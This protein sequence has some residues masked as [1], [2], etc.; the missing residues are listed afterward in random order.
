[1]AQKDGEPDTNAGSSAA[2]AATIAPISDSGTEATI[3]APSSTGPTNPH[4]RPLAE[5][6]PEVSAAHY[7][8][9]REIARG[10]M[11][12]IVAAE[13]R[14]LH[15]RV[16]LKSL[17][18]PAGDHI[19]RFQREALITARLQHPGIVPVYEAGKWPNGEPFFAMKL[20]SGRPLDKVIAEASRLEDR[21][22]IIP[23][24]AAACD[25]IAYAHSQ[26]IIHR[27]LKPGN[28]LIGDYGET[29]V[30]DWGLAKD[31]DAT[32]THDSYKRD[33]KP[34][35]ARDEATTQ[36]STLTIAGAVMGTPAYMAPEQARGEPLDQ[37]ADVFSLGAMLYHTL[38][39]VP[40]YNARTATDVIAAAALGKIVPLSQRER[41]AP[42]DLVAIVTRAMA[43][44]PYD[45]YPDA[46]ELASELRRFLTGQLVGAHRYTTLQRVTRFVRMHRAAVTISVVA[47]AGFA[48][49][50]TVAI[51]NIVEARDRARREEQIAIT[52]QEA[53]EHLIDYMLDDMKTRLS[54][55]GRLD[56]L[57]GLGNEVKNYYKKLSDMPGG[58]P[59]EDEIRM[60]QAIELIG[61]AEQTSG[62]PDQALATWREARE[63]LTT[64]IGTDTSAATHR[65]RMMIARFDYEAGR[66]F[67]ERGKPKEALDYFEKAKTAFDKLRD[68]DPRDK[69][70][71]LAAGDTH[72]RLG[73]LLRIDGKIDEAFDEYNAGKAEREKAQQLGDG[74]TSDALLAVSTSHFKLA[75][76]F[77]NRGE[78][79]AAL[80]EYQ[81][82]RRL[83][84]TLLEG[85]PDNVQYQEAVLDVQRELGELQRQL[86][87]TTAAI[88]T[89]K[90]ALPVAQSLM[91]RDPT[92]TDWQYA[93]GNLMS[94]LGY[95]LI[96][97]GAYND[98]IAR[99]TEAAEV[100][101]GLVAL[102]PKSA[103]YRTALS[104]T[105]MRM[106]DAHLALGQMAEALTD[107]RQALEL[108]EE[109][110]D[111]DTKNVAYRR[112]VAWAYAKLAM[113][114]TTSGREPQ[115]I[116]AHE[117]ALDIRKALV[118]ESPSQGGFKNELASSEVELGRLLAAKE[119]KRAAELIKSGLD[120]AH[121]LVAGDMINIEWKETLTQGLLA[122]A[123]LA[124][125][126]ADTALRDASLQEA[127]DV[128]TDALSHAPHNAS[129]PCYLAEIH[130]ARREWKLARDLLEPLDKA[131]RLP[132]QRRPLLDRARAQR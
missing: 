14:R 12:K 93:R 68:E 57:A 131:S 66:V 11:G 82:A 106:G 104:K 56:L 27:D 22:A 49:G 1:M 63:R 62:N 76:I 78:S 53:A 130:I 32:D 88:D 122:R 3:A 52:R 110:I 26:R 8:T 31:L 51:N 95:T 28:V 128:A 112:S 114:Y 13:D 108:R 127:L 7:V 71:L 42:A 37:R 38:A 101:R 30:I 69:A 34:K 39:G 86:G 91:Q 48:I 9:E 10:G 129:W 121:M 67:Q 132:A 98:G 97:S 21:L 80:E 64:V 60:A 20:V 43:Q 126:T 99:V 41:R 19:T 103:R 45:R 118:A 65:L 18:D 15:R 58:M 73:D 120:R 105:N 119:P 87:D 5:D 77:Q 124:T 100:L 113:A 36:S 96:D 102:D 54:A 2:F 107:Y 81:L 109:L 17:L 123:A 117:H 47:L 61:T 59:R 116:E 16:A 83:R 55:A 90:L 84:D 115:A 79:G 46:G 29:V 75:S 33:P 6:F 44:S 24:L 89:Y 70:V 4:S 92:N 111:A 35:P 40:P 23:R 125:A 50:G 74:R 72:D 94:D 85:A 25:A